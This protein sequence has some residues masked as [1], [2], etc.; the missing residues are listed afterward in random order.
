M[1]GANFGLISDVG[2]KGG[3]TAN[4]AGDQLIDYYHKFKNI[5]NI[6]VQT[7]ADDSRETV[8]INGDEYDKDG[9]A[10][11]YVLQQLE[12]EFNMGFDQILKNIKTEMDFDSKIDSLFASA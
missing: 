11:M 1:I 12:S 5:M 8:E 4:T 2:H 7:L 9:T 3:T 10:Q 6:Y